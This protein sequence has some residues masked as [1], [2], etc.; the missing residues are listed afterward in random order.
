M[1]VALAK[2]PIIDVDAHWSEPPDLWTSRAPKKLRERVPRVVRNDEGKDRWLVDTD[3]E[4]G[5]LGYCVV[6][7]DGT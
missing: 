6:R 7:K 3:L 5:P 2:M 4:F 1:D